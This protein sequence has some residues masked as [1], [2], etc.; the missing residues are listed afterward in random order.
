M[1]TTVLLIVLGALNGLV[2]SLVSMCKLGSDYDRRKRIRFV[3]QVW[4]FIA[5]TAAYSVCVCL[6]SDA[7]STYIWTLIVCVV[8]FC[9]AFPAL[10]YM[11]CAGHLPN[12]MPISSEIPPR[13]KRS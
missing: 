8:S 6:G 2:V 12:S 10:D 4:A 1:I 7:L 3:P 11:W 9:S 5:A 13:G